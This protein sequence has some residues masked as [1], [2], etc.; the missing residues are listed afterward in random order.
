M[1]YFVATGDYG[2]AFRNRLPVNGA[3]SRLLNVPRIVFYAKDKI[4][5]MEN[6]QCTVH[7]AR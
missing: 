4:F 1:Q 2:K 6:R 5:P 3:V 7:Y